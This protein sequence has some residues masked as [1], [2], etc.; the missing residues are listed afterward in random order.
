MVQYS[1]FSV[2]DNAPLWQRPDPYLMALHGYGAP[3]AKGGKQPQAGKGSSLVPNKV[4]WTPQ[5]FLGLVN[6]WFTPEVQNSY[7]PDIKDDDYLNSIL[8]NKIAD[9]STTL[10]TAHQRGQLTNKGYEGALA[11]LGTQRDEGLSYLQDL[12]GG[13]VADRRL[14]LGEEFAKQREASSK[15]LDQAPGFGDFRNSLGNKAAELNATDWKTS[16]TDSLGSSSLFDFNPAWTAATV[17]GPVNN[18]AA[19]ALALKNNE[20]YPLSD[21]QRSLLSTGV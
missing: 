12:T 21:Y 5:N 1:D 4:D 16:L 13:I 14:Q 6:D 18:R 9:T 3:N 2:D 7:I 17:Q 10:D 11:N 19:N 15:I 8:D 20:K